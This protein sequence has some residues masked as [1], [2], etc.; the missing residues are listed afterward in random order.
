MIRLKKNG[1]KQEDSHPDTMQ[2]ATGQAETTEG[3]E[4]RLQLTKKKRPKK[5]R[6]RSLTEN[7]ENTEEVS[8]KLKEKTRQEKI[9]RE[10][11]EIR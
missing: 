5:T 9:N 10:I 4:K 1:K 11:H 8:C 6:T 2:A 3:T 7:T